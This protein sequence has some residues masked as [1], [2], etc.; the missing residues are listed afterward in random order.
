MNTK[1]LERGSNDAFI[2]NDEFVIMFAI[3]ANVWPAVIVKV[4]EFTVPVGL[5]TSI[6]KSPSVKISVPFKPVTVPDNV[7]YSSFLPSINVDLLFIVP[8]V[9]PTI[10]A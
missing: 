4:L 10:C 9:K 7:E 3:S 1:K 6:V 8:P 5:V 2:P